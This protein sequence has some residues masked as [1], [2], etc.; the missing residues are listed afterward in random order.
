[1]GSRMQIKEGGESMINS[2]RKDMDEL[3]IVDSESV[4][5]VKMH[6]LQGRTPP[7][8]NRQPM[9]DGN[10]Q[11]KMPSHLPPQ[12]PPQL[13]A[14]PMA[15]PTQ[16]CSSHDYMSDPSGG[17]QK[18][19]QPQNNQQLHPNESVSSSKHPQESMSG[20]GSTPHSKRDQDQLRHKQKRL[21]L[22]HHSAQCQHKAG[23]CLVTP[24]C[25]MMKQLWEHITQCKVVSC[26][27]PHCWSSRYILSHYRKCKDSN[28]QGCNPVREI[29]RNSRSPRKW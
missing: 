4:E 27:F 2:M 15:Q 11:N 14:P 21:I 17:P 5:T 9:Q 10:S 23:K 18:Q 28:C 3:S 29:I 24:H 1:M 8:P 12:A 7:P 6:N 25:T 16:P 26:T 19:Q 13:L 20:H 22:L